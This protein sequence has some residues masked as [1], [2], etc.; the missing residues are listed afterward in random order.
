MTHASS[1]PTVSTLA[2][3]V[4]TAALTAF[5]FGFHLGEVNQPRDAMSNC[6]TPVAVTDDCISMDDWAWHG[7]TLPS[8]PRR[9]CTGMLTEYYRTFSRKK[10]TFVSIFVL[11][12]TVGAL[13]GGSLAQSLGR[14]R[15]LF[16]NNVP[17]IIAS[18]LLASSTTVYG[19]YAGRFIGGIAAGVGT[20]GVPLYIAEVAPVGIRGSL[21]ALNQLSIVIGIL[22]SQ[23][24]GIPLSTRTGWRYLFF[25]G[26]LPPLLQCFLLPFCVE[27]PKWLSANGLVID[28][29]KALQRLR[30]SSSTEA[31]IDQEFDG[32][33]NNGATSSNTDDAES[34]TLSRDPDSLDESAPLSGA[35]QHRVTI[36]LRDLFHTASLR[37]PLFAAFGLQ[38]AQQLSGVNA[39]VF[40]STTIF[41]QSY[42]PEVSIKLSLLVSFVN[43]VMTLVSMGLIERLGRKT[44]LLVSEMGMMACGVSIFVSV[45]AALAPVFV[46][47]SLLGFVGFFGIGLGAI[48]W[49]IL[50]E[51]VPGYAVNTAASVCSGLNWGSSW[52]VAF[53]LPVL[54][55]WLGYDIFLV[56]SFFL[57]G[58]ALFTQRY[59]PETKGL[60]PEEVARINQF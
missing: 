53:L 3:C 14:R 15:L 26:L 45:K 2:L 18:A 13:C 23:S 37:R 47:L 4:G 55:G 8:S 5:T 6:T 50:P 40:Y 24:L 59:V 39:A 17:F 36:T 31:E 12:G 51:L 46:V 54:I 9:Q 21:G 42:P 32:I 38:L 7:S 35:Q 33:A 44:L 60:T 16:L 52:I 1:P 41:N 56:F 25:A 20:V 29:R 34:A 27:S 57:A 43:L 30:S 11:G 49:L 48:P 10:G 28:A 58:F 19:L 22:C